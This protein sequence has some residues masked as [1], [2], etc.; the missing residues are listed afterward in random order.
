MKNEKGITL[1]SLII[2]IIGLLIVMGILSTFMNFF[3]RNI[4]ENDSSKDSEEYSKLILYMTNDINSKNI[5]T[6]YPE[7]SQDIFIRFNDG[8][9]HKY[10][11]QNNKI[12]YIEYNNANNPIKTISLCNNVETCSFEYDELNNKITTSVKIK[13]REY[14]NNFNVQM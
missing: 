7:N 4:N 1:T 11:C 13:G 9:A 3:Y 10:S 5:K 8:T 6:I 12:Y 2:Y 14:I